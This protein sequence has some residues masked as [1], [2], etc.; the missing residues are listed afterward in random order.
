MTQA[1][2]N[3]MGELSDVRK[4]IDQLDDQLLA[5][6]AQRRALAERV[7]RI[8]HAD[9]T[10]LRDEQREGE[11]LRAR[12]VEGRALGL[13]AQ[14]ITKIFHE[15]LA[16]S[17]RLQQTI[18]QSELNGIKSPTRVA[19]QGIDGSYSHLLGRTIFLNASTKTP[20]S[21]TTRDQADFI[22]FPSYKKAVEA[23]E[24]GKCDCAILPIENTTSGG[25]NDVYDLLLNSRVSIVGEEKFNV[26][27]CL[28]G[29]EDVPANH[30]QVVHCSQLAI[31]ECAHFL[32]TIP[33]CA[34]QYAN[35][36]ATALKKLQESGNKF[37]AAIG[38]EEAAEMLGLKVLKSG[39]SNHEENFTRY[40]IV[41]KTPTKVDARIPSKVSIVMNTL[42]KPGALVDTL[43]V[44][45][46]HGINL[47]KLESRPIPGNSWE[48]MFYIDFLG[49]LE[50]PNVTGA[51]SEVTKLARFIKVL[52][53]FPACD[54]IPTP[55]PETEIES[56]VKGDSSAQRIYIEVNEKSPPKSSGKDKGYKLASRDHKSSNTIIT[57]G[58]VSIGDGNFLV[59]AGPCSVESRDQIMACAKEARDNGARILRGGVF[60]PR[61]SPY[62]FQGLGYEGLDLLV[63]AGKAF[64]MPVITEVMTTED[65]ER[66]AEKADILQIGARNMQ[67][68][69]LLKA[70]GETRR[71]VMLK[72]GLSAPIEELLQ[73]TEY[74][75]AGGNQQVFLCERGIRTFETATRGTLDIS[76]VPVLKAKTHLPIFIDPSHAAG[77]RELVPPLALAAKAVGAD[78]IIVEFHPE[79]EK[80]L[81]DGPQALRFP[82]FKKLMSD[83][84]KLEV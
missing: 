41:A 57:V 82:Q 64:G 61:T 71:P 42:N 84:R 16:D 13:D 17:N 51:I 33:S 21:D 15:V 28:V 65:V 49:N 74:I 58:G 10:P 4:N 3:T 32:A 24:S 77:V 29:L 55:V 11:I 9:N 43:V 78:G 1:L 81:S 2:S 30:L 73:A 35:D 6:L 53:C 70:I 8:K 54:I 47:T 12:I 59:I 40:L 27:H 56:T 68:Y 63:E 44:F 80:A 69:S 83:L 18:L 19:F 48:E 79:P 45:K 76:A 72:R 38:S 52:G 37:H 62:S 5:L 66:V 46:E 20:S 23:V 7:I 25:I 22:G 26:Q 60:K 34:V 75:L 36:S 67:N 39:I 14:L 50:A 31:S